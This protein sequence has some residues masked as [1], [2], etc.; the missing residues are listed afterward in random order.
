[1]C[2][3]PGLSADSHKDGWMIPS[4]GKDPPS[5]PLS[6]G[7]L[8]NSALTH[9]SPCLNVSPS[10]G[11]GAISANA[12]HKPFPPSSVTSLLAPESQSPLDKTIGGFF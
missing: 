3:C 9:L 12:S 1:M 6:A 4:P 2:T 7:S 5:T 11:V 10:L 8:M